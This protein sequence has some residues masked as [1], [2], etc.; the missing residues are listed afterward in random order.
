[1]IAYKRIVTIQNP[2]KLVLNDLP[3]QPGQR[4]EVVLLA[5]EQPGFSLAEL[6]ALFQETQTLPTAQTITEEEIMTEI[7]AYRAEQREGRN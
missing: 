5:E 2:R 3:F 1:M 4:V 6:Q 7:E